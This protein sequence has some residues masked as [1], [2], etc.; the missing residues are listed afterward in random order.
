[1]SQK[2][3]N[4][5]PSSDR[6]YLSVFRMPLGQTIMGRKTTITNAFVNSL[7]PAVYPDANEI[8][9]AIQI[10]G[11]RVED[12]RCTYCGD[13]SSEWDHLRPLVVH[14][15]PTGFISE[16]ANLVPSCGKCNQS[17]GNRN[18]RDWM[19]ST[20]RHSPTA[21]QIAQVGERVNRLEAFEQWKRPIKIDFEC[22]FAVGKWSEY[23][24]MC[25]RVLDEMKK[26]QVIADSLRITITESLK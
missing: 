3:V 24:E 11:L 22:L 20:A 1:M 8:R 6:D 7:I 17:K 26:C 13:K 5:P 4:E 15:R 16:I 21:R 25:E 12:L 2:P 23:W 14:R 10:L 9:T 19:L 18:W